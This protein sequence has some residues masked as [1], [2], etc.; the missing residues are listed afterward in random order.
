MTPAPSWPLRAQRLALAVGTVLLCAVPCVRAAPLSPDHYPSLV[1]T[2][3]REAV[4]GEADA[5]YALAVVLLCGTQVP[6]D[7]ASAALWLALLAPAGHA[8]A[9]SVLG[10]QLMT[11][12]GVLRDDRHAARWLR[13]AA[14]QGD[15]A[16]GNNLGVLFALGRGVPRDRA[17]AER[18]FRTAAEQGAEAA[19][20]NLAVLLGRDELPTVR[21]ASP[22]ASGA[23]G[24]AAAH[25]ALTTAACQALSRT[26]SR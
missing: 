7:P 4:A 15:T 13:D 23:P 8:G 5:R 16:A 3:H 11:G 14:D 22:G 10:W 19:A 18:L 17:A 9:Q 2:L 12:T 24:P 26:F 1:A 20:R 25:P 6:R 21:S